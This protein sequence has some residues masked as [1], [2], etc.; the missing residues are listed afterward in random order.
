MMR[1][2][3]LLSCSFSIGLGASVFANDAT[4]SPVSA[5]PWLTESLQTPALTTTEP[6]SN[7]STLIET[8]SV[9]TLRDND[10]DG[11]GILKTQLTGFPYDLW[12]EQTAPT[13]L[14]QIAQ[15]PYGG[16]P[17]IRSLFRQVLLAVKHRR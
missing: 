7:S 2:Q 3:L 11:L 6:T 14:R 12:G 8:I 16:V 4:S 10:R 13:V 15:T 9:E 17:A 1:N 5:I